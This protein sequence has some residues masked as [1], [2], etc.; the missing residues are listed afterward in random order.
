M[1]CLTEYKDWFCKYYFRLLYGL[2]GYYEIYF[3]KVGLSYHGIVF[4][5]FFSVTM[6]KIED[7]KLLVS[8]G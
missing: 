4:E 3:S 5:Q 7:D 6:Y 1:L 8:L 2:N